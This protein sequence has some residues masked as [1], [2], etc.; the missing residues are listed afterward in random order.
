MT[1][2]TEEQGHEATQRGIDDALA[3]KDRDHAPW[4]MRSRDSVESTLAICYQR[5]YAYG[6][7]IELQRRY[8]DL[9]AA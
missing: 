9:S 8:G 3:G 1:F 4:S 6:I 2:P 7:Q 5:G